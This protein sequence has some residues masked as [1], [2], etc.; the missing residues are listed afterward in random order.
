MHSASSTRDRR[1]KVG[2]IVAA[3]PEK[4]TRIMLRQMSYKIFKKNE[5]IIIISP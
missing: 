4:Q 5:S 3:L 1:L 2:C